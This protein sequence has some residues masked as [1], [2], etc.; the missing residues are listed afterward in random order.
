MSAPLIVLAAGGTGGHVF[1]AEALA[2]EL[3]ARGVGVALFTDRRGR[4]FGGALADVE[5]VALSA[6]GVAGLR[7][8][9]KLRSAVA[10]LRG[11]LEATHHLQ[12]LRP[13]A[14]VGFGGYT[15]A[16]AAAAALRLGLPLVIHEQNAVLG[17]AN[18]LFAARAR[19]LATSFPSVARVPAA[20]GGCTRCVGMPVR[21]AVAAVRADAYAA[22]PRDGRTRLLVLG[23]SQGAHVFSEIV[24]QAVALLPPALRGCLDIAQQCR[25]E[26]IDAARAAFAEAGVAPELATFFDDVPARLARAHLVITRAGASTVAE[27]AVAGRPAVLIPYPHAADDHQTANARAFDDAGAAWL[28]PQPAFTAEALAARLETVLTAP[29]ALERAA[30]AARALGRPDAANALAD[31]VLEAAGM[32]REAA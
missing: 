12:R 31:A 7:L 23:G 26:D 6:G 9:A 1:P 14:V 2:A 17:R 20:S 25:A 27:L 29:Q 19:L 15:S 24:P 5:T 28:M 30:A 22:P 11:T 18:R 4:A 10:L 21:P 13:A 3:K 32:M 16:P 8:M